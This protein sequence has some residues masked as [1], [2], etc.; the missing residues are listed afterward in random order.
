MLIQIKGEIGSG[1]TLFARQL[2]ESLTGHADFKQMMRYKNQLFCSSLN[3]ESQYSFL[4]IW[5]P[6]FTQLV[7]YYC[8]RENVRREQVVLLLLSLCPGGLDANQ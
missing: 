3:P 7:T 1:K 8:K 2:I 6:I 5:R 4:N